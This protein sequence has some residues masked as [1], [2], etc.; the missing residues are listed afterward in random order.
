MAI[1][2]AFSSI[3]STTCF[4]L[5]NFASPAL[6]SGPVFNLDISVS[7]LS[8]NLLIKST[9]NLSASCSN[10][11]PERMGVFACALSAATISIPPIVLLILLNSSATS[12]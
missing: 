8:F 10:A 1:W 12:E 2:I 4:F 3:N 11:F 6:P 7:N 5:S 9:T